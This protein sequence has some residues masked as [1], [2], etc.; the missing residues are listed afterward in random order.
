MKTAFEKLRNKVEQK[1][2]KTA[3][4]RAAINP[5]PTEIEYKLGVFIEMLE[6]Q[7]KQAVLEMN[8]KGYST[9]ISGFMDNPSEQMIEGDFSLDDA[10]VRKLRKV[11]VLVEV[12]ASSY[13]KLQF[14]TPDA[15]IQKIKRKWN[16]IVSLLPSKNHNADPSMTRKAREFR[17]KFR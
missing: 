17:V 16:T 8:K 9:D 13:T 11:G 2:L 10:T 3:N 15:D 5:H 12:T 14:S 6:P 1:R 4:H 7:V